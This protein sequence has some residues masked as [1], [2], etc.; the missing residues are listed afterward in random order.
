[1][2]LVAALQEHAAIAPALALALDNIRRAPLQMQLDIA[3][4]APTF[5][6][7]SPANNCKRTIR[8]PPFDL[9]AI[10]VLPLGSIPPI[11]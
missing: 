6:V 1:M 4:P 5:N 9:T 7:S 10:L 11:E 2:Y 3:E 8:K